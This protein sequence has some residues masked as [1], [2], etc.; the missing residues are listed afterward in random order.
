MNNK[1]PVISIN[2]VTAEQ[3]LNWVLPILGAL[4]IAVVIWYIWRYIKQSNQA[5]RISEFN[6]KTFKK[7][8]G[9]EGAVDLLP[10]CQECK[11]AMRVEIKYK[12]FMK[13]TGDFLVSRDSA[14]PALRTFVDMERITQEDLDRQSD[15]FAPD[16]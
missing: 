14:E 3:V 10:F 6:E 13:D 9:D 5:G 1:I 15:P 11:M 16:E 4:I 7:L 2:D 12:D 8:V